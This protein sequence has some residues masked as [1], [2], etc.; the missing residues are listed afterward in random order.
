MCSSEL[1]LSC[2]CPPPNSFC[3]LRTDISESVASNCCGS[4]TRLAEIHLQVAPTGEGRGEEIRAVLT[5][6]T[7]PRRR[8][9]TCDGARGSLREET[10]IDDIPGRRSNPAP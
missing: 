10:Q 6:G 5:V 4:D 3:G 2:R 8:S 9:N 7:P 1:P